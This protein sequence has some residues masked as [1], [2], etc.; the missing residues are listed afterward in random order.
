M[1]TLP[2][3]QVQAAVDR[4]VAMNGANDWKDAEAPSLAVF[5]VLAGMAWDRLPGHFRQ[6]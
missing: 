3:L 6:V 1:H 5:E 2:V 4:E